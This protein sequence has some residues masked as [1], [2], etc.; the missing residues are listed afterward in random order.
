[1][2]LAIHG[3]SKIVEQGNLNGVYFSNDRSGCAVG[4]EEL[5][6]ILLMEEYLAKC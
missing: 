4:I 5:Q 6:Y 3:N 1:M 2:M